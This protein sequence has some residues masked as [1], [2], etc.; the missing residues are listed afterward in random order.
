MRLKSI[1]FACAALLTAAAPAAALAD[2]WDHDGW[3]EHEWRENAWRRHEWREH[4]AWEHRGGWG[5]YGGPRC[6]VEN[7]GHYDWYGN[8]VYQP[9]RICWR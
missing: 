8:Y 2:P 1:L 9:V 7:R 4:E 6:V 3:R 5:W